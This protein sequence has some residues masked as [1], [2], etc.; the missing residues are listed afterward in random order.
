M[1]IDFCLFLCL[2]LMDFFSKKMM[3]FFATMFFTRWIFHLSLC[4][5]LGLSLSLKARYIL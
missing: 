3:D 5:L 4:V 2:L 1:N